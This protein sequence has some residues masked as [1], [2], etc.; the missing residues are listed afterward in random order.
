[1]Q[2]LMRVFI[3]SLVG[4][5][6]ASASAQLTISQT[7]QGAFDDQ[8]IDSTGGIVTF[9]STLGTRLVIQDP[10]SDTYAAIQIRDRKSVQ[11]DTGGWLWNRV[12]IGDWISFSNV[13]V[14][15]W[16]G[17]T[18]L[19]FNNPDDPDANLPLSTY[20]IVSSGNPLPSPV[21]V[22]LEQIQAPTV[23]GGN[24]TIDPGQLENNRQLE[25]MR[26]VITDVQVTELNQGRFADNYLVR[27][28]D[29]GS[30]TGA[31]TYVAD[32]NNYNRGEGNLYHPAVYVGAEFDQI[33]G[34]MERSRSSSGSSDY[35][36]LVT[37]SSASFGFP[38]PGDFDGDGDADGRDF[39]AWQRGASPSAYSTTDLETWQDGYSANGLA[40]GVSIPEPGASVTAIGMLLAMIPSS[41]STKRWGRRF[42]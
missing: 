1:M 32:Y 40:A 16:T 19:H 31:S 30:G 23:S 3:V 9:K 26:V 17:N 21:P 10:N 42:R 34:Y 35:Y 24:Y 33:V 2:H 4:S 37:T 11:G 20:T 22:N 12:E 27:S 5:M 38:T 6:A 8:A 7:R 41:R 29:D 36:Q 25:G 39:L 18:M 13:F 28:Q 14:T 15:S